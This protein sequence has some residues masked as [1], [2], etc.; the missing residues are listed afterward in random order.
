MN[1]AVGPVGASVISF[2][3][4]LSIAGAANAHILT[5]PRVY[6]AMASDGLFF[7]KMAS[8]HPRY[9]TPH[10]SILVVGAWAL[11]LSLSGSF[12]QL[13]TYVVFGHWIFMGLAVSAVVVLRAKRPD[14]PRPY[15]ALGYPLTPALFVL[16]AVFVTVNALINAFW[17]SFA[18]LAI[19]LLG[20]PAF[21]FWRSKGAVAG[22]KKG[23]ALSE[24]P[25]PA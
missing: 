21:L 18:G 3:I 14:L 10:V 19:I 16:A 17:N 11:F 23:A 12:E 22:E 6:F 24:E 7:K 9:R 4:L 20:I 25:P 2:I 13:L 5:G 1:A 15:R 8:V